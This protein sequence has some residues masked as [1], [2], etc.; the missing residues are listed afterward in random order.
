MTV[1]IRAGD[2][3]PT[4]IV[5]FNERGVKCSCDDYV[6]RRGPFICSHITELSK[7]VSTARINDRTIADEIQ[8]TGP[9]VDAPTAAAT[10]EA[11][12]VGLR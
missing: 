5:S 2:N 7:L 3:T 11:D 10:E 1:C 8:L 4:R 6:Y 9:K 12:A